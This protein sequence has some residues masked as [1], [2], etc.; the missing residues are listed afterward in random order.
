MGTSDFANL[1]FESSRLKDA[2]I[3]S[4]VSAVTPLEQFT[5]AQAALY[6]QRLHNAN[7]IRRI[8]LQHAMY[9]PWGWSGNATDPAES[10]GYT[11][12]ARTEARAI[13]DELRALVASPQS[14]DE[15][16]T[17]EDDTRAFITG[18]RSG[19]AAA[20]L[21]QNFSYGEIQPLADPMRVSA[22]LLK[23]LQLLRYRSGKGLSPEALLD[24]G[25]RIGVRVNPDTAQA[26]SAVLN[27]ANQLV[28][29][30]LLSTAAQDGGLIHISVAT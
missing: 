3:A 17:W 27:A 18:L 12:E 28:T 23:R 10:V 11:E 9:L 6:R 13:Y 29:E 22:V 1:L 25:T 21:S 4:Y 20:R 2:T 19:V 8:S 14:D 26:R 5:S 15:D 30:G 24:D 7:L 16:V